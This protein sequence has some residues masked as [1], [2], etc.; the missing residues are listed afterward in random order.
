MESQ[1]AVN[2]LIK[3]L[4][5]CLSIDDSKSLLNAKTLLE[6][7]VSSRIA[8][9]VFELEPP[10]KNMFARSMLNVDFSMHSRE[11]A[12][13]RRF[14]QGML[15]KQEVALEYTALIKTSSDYSQSIM[16]HLLASL[17]YLQHLHNIP[18]SS[19]AERFAIKKLII[20]LLDEV[21]LKTRVYHSHPGFQLYAETIALKIITN[22][23]Q[24]SKDI[25]SPEDNSLAARIL[26]VV[27]RKCRMC[28][29]VL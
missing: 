26:S 9:L 29:L 3:I 22:I 16:C 17:W 6:G 10:L 27:L 7:K 12:I 5:N 8:N 19:K 20:H 24:T 15:S 2:I 4:P 11:D 25:V 13:L 18:K 28:P 14:Q 23:L 1:E 21:L